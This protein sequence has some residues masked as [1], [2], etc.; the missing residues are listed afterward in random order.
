[1]K[2][3]VYSVQRLGKEVYPKTTG[4]GYITDSDLVI[5]CL[6]QKDNPYIRVFD[7]A[8]KN[9]YPIYGRDG[10]FKGEHTEYKE[11]EVEKESN[12]YVSMETIEIQ[13]RYRIWYKYADERR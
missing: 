13:I 7:D 6:S 11:I 4:V 12:G 2:K 8:V 3:V 5:A 10:E 9:C 1:M